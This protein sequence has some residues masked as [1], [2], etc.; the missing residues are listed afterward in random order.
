MQLQIEKIGPAKV[1][2]VISGDQQTLNK[3]K[4]L[5]LKKLGANVKVPGFRDGTAPANLIEKQID[6]NSLQAEFI[7]Y[8]ISELYQQAVIESKTRV[9]GQPEVSITKL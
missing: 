5:A 8:A 7:N 2:F 9:V 1:K 4:E 3:A 6:P